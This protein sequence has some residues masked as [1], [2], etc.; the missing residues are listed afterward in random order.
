MDNRVTL[1]G[2]DLI[3]ANKY[4]DQKFILD[5]VQGHEDEPRLIV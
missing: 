4:L 3:R 2:F 1:K 5:V